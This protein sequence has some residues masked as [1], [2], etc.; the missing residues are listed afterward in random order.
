[1]DEKLDMGT[2]KLVN[3]WHKYCD[4]LDKAALD[5]KKLNLM[6]KEK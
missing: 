1:M 4:E 2:N 3:N 6:Q 5:K